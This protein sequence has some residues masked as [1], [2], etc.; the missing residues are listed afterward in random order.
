M[1]RFLKDTNYYT[2][3]KLN[4]KSELPITTKAIELIILK[5]PIKKNPGPY[6]L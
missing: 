4:R 1:D 6:G 2:G 3:S 5:I